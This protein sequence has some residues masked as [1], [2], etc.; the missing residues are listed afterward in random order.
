MREFLEQYACH[1]SAFF[2][3]GKYVIAI[4]I[5]PAPPGMPNLI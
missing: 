1:S 5:E 2:S 3:S 4:G